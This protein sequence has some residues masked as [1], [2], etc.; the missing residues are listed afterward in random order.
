MI[1]KMF[2]PLLLSLI[3]S[4][5]VHAQERTLFEEPF[6]GK[7][8][9]GWAWL[10]E[11][12]S[13]WRIKDKALEVKMIPTPNT[14]TDVRNILHRKPPKT[15]DGP[16]EVSV[17]V[18]VSQPYTNQY[19]QAGLFWM[20]G[21]KH[22]HKFVMER[23][24]GELYVFPGKVPIESEHVVLRLRIDGNKIIAEFQPKATGE[25]RKAY[26]ATLPNR[27]DDTDRIALQCWHG[28]ANAESWT[29]FKNFTISKPKS[30]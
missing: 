12:P 9:E 10:R 4:L 24:D 22:V 23:I 21:E 5:F 28:P 16:F 18:N 3:L 2:F 6:D 27:N 20:Q 8:K 15:E 25:F 11:V 7:L 1:R 29:Q 17:E 30:E 19:Q 26:D 13:D 14:N